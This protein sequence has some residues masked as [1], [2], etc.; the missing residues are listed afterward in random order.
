MSIRTPFA[1][2]YRKS[3]SW[4]KS[5]SIRQ[6]IALRPAMDATRQDLIITSENEKEIKEFLY[7]GTLDLKRMLKRAIYVARN[8]GQS[9]LILQSAGSMGS[10]PND[11]VNGIS[12]VSTL[13]EEKN[14]K[15][16]VTNYSTTD[17]T[18]IHPTRVFRFY[19]DEPEEDKFIPSWAIV[20][21]HIDLYNEILI[22][23][24]RTIK[25][26]SIPVIK[27]MNL[28]QSFEEGTGSDVEQTVVKKKV[29]A[30]NDALSNRAMMMLDKD[31]DDF[32]FAG[33]TLAGIAEVATELKACIAGATLP[34]L[35]L[36]DKSPQGISGSRKE[37]LENYYN[38]V[39]QIREEGCTSVINAL[40]TAKFGSLA[41][42]EWEYPHL[43]TPSEIEIEQA[44]LAIEQTKSAKI[45]NIVKM[46]DLLG[47][48]PEQR[49]IL[50]KNEG[51]I[52]ED[53][54]VIDDFSDMDLLGEPET[55]GIEA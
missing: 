7:S 5:Q 4:K 22:D 13:N 14:T 50:I 49:M 19:G 26:S 1:D 27:T 21:E 23:G 33:R 35:I 29:T 9:Y 18:K 17:I 11:L 53:F 37:Q 31:E 45:D 54:K 20:D 8:T 12:V 2:D 24:G 30:I 34:E 51:L 32:A 47:L 25:A 16:V 6:T 48:M 10:P 52:P 39:N 41:G 42:I 38:I 3:F 55:T 28:N 40:L 44:N 43:T 46:T 15:G 36:F